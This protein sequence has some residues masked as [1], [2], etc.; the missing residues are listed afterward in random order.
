MLQYLMPKHNFMIDRGKR[1]LKQNI[2]LKYDS[3][4]KTEKAPLGTKAAAK[5]FFPN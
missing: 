5:T 2:A 1:I 3:E 4:N